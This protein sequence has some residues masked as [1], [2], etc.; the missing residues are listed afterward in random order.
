MIEPLKC[1][2]ILSF[3]SHTTY[4]R[5]GSD[6]MAFFH[7]SA[8]FRRA[9]SFNSESTKEYHQVI[10]PLHGLLVTRVRV[11]NFDGG[12]KLRY[13]GLSS[14]GRP[15][16]EGETRGCWS[17]NK[18]TVPCEAE[19]SP[20]LSTRQIVLGEG[21]LLQLGNERLVLHHLHI[22]GEH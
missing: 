12:L 15:E 13:R 11:G 5:D 9:A 17:K 14:A 7:C 10:C 22:M 1:E 16:N 18:M 20:R 4:H 6:E 19:G 8:I 21:T 2:S 3:K